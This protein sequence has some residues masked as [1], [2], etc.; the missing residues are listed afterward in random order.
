S[1]AAPSVALGVLAIGHLQAAE[2]LG[3]R[4]AHGL[5]GFATE[6]DVNGLAADDVAAPGH[7]VGRGDAAG[8]RHADAGVVGI[9]GVQRPQTG[10]GRASHLVAVL[11]GVDVRPGVDADVRVGINHS[12]DDRFTAQ[13]VCGCVAGD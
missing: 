7:D 1:L 13:I 6:L 2:D 3:V 4:N 8:D 5:D 9:D 11:V 12:G 10:L